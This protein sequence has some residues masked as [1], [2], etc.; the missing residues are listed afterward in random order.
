MLTLLW[1]WV[2]GQRAEP[3]STLV[4]GP[5]L[6]DRAVLDLGVAMRG[7]PWPGWWVVEADAKAREAL[8]ARGAWLTWPIP[9]SAARMPGCS[10]ELPRLDQIHGPAQRGE[11]TLGPKVVDEP[12]ARHG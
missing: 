7:R 8:R 1:S 3:V 12:P 5:S 11:H 10:S 9:Q 4:W 2:H 6:I